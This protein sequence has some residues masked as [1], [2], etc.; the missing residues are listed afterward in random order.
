VLDERKIDELER[1]SAI[2]FLRGGAQAEAEAR[3]EYFA[4]EKR[5]EELAREQWQVLLK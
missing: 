5:R 4:Q 2:A 1:L 3:A